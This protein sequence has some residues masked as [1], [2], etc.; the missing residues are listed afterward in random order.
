MAEDFTDE[1][2]NDY[3]YGED[4]A[5]FGDR[6][7][8]ARHYAGLD[9]AEFA[10]RLGVKHDTVVG[11]EDD[12]REPRANKLQMMAGLLGVSVTWLL[13]GEGEGVEA[14]PGEEENQAVELPGILVEIRDIRTQMKANL[15]RLARL[16]KKLRVAAAEGPKA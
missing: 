12:I 9:Q 3:W 6:L 8:A 11:W 13:T 14:A 16:E 5:T 7:A 15:D 2:Y 1:D 10:R 4:V